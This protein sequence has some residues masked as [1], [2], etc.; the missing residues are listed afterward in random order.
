[1]LSAVQV[2][3]PDD[4]ELFALSLLQG[5]HGPLHVQKIPA[6]HKGDYGIDCYCTK[7][8]VAYQCYAVDE[9]ID[10]ATRAD[11]QKKKITIDLRKLLTNHIEVAKMFHGVPI[12]HWVLI[13]PLH[14]SKEVNLHC[15]KKTKDLRT[16][17]CVAFDPAIEVM[18]Q[19]PSAFP[20]DAV[21]IGMSA[22]SKV[23]LSIP[24]P[25]QT[26][27]ATWVAGSSDLLAN[28]TQKLRKRAAADQLDDVVAEAV[29]SFL[30]GNA[31]LDALRSGSPDLHEKVMSAIRSRARRLQFAGPQP[32]DSAGEILNAELDALITAMQTAAPSLSTENAEQIAYGS[33]CEWIM[34][35][36]LDFPNVQ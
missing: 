19:D 34:R 31:L 32:G 9:P 7:D 13:A 1:M 24:V 11:R 14:D 27:L 26:E 3:N 21:A 28:A 15:A 8:C 4:W 2:W 12:R 25:S 35:C 6:A 10:I 30:Q 36:P 16:A 33:I 5:R 23:T 22:L 20:T 17:G 18:I 29:R